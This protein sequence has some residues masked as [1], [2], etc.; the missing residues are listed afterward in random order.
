MYHYPP[1]IS[2]V[3]S[4]K[5]DQLNNARNEWIA[6]KSCSIRLQKALGYLEIVLEGSGRGTVRRQKSQ[7]QVIPESQGVLCFTHLPMTDKE[8]GF[9]TI[10]IQNLVYELIDF[11]CYCY[12]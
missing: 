6:L 11:Q 2:K 8:P 4:D 3:R 1:V 9:A 5:G 7:S 10:S 12:N